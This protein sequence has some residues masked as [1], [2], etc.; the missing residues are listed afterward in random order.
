[1]P[2]W[3]GTWFTDHRNDTGYKS[4]KILSTIH[5]NIL[6]A[7]RKARRECLIGCF[8]FSPFS[9]LKKLGSAHNGILATDSKYIIFFYY[10]VISMWHRAFETPT[11]RKITDFP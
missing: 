1:M 11:E 2:F 8:I 7:E 10:D 4:K 6:S 5:L 9:K 3:L